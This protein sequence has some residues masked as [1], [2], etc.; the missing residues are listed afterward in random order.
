MAKGWWVKR[1]EQMGGAPR[2]H[3]VRLFSPGKGAGRVPFRVGDSGR[4]FPTPGAEKQQEEALKGSVQSYREK[5]KGKA[6]P[7][8]SGT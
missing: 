7:Q 4:D 2:Q 3:W 6:L 1:V 5:N 8:P